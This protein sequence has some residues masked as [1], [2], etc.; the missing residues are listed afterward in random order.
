MV[1][2]AHHRGVIEVYVMAKLI[3]MVCN[4]GDIASNSNRS[5]SSVLSIA[6]LT[7]SFCESCGC[8][9]TKTL[10]KVGFKS[11]N[12]LGARFS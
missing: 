3:G 7:L 8:H 9:A 10:I 5:G 4:H 1:S 6:L 11:L 12:F 2:L